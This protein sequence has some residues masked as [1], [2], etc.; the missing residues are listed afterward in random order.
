M[1]VSVSVGICAYNEAAR[2]GG[3]LGSLRSVD[4]SPSFIVDEIL[5]VASG[6][7]DGTEEEV[8]RAA[9]H[10]ARIR[11]VVEPTRRGK[12]SALNRILASYRGDILVLV[13]ADARPAPGALGAL[14]RAFEEPADTVVACGAAVPDGGDGLSHLVEEVQWDLHNRILAIQSARNQENH[15]CDELMA[16]R[17]GF[18][19]S[20]PPDLINDGAY[21]GVFAALSGRTVRFCTDARVHVHTP[22]S[23]RG[24]VEQRRRIL[25]G[26]RQIRRMLRR[27]P[28]TLER[29]ST[30]DP[31]LAA[32]IL[33]TEIR[34]RPLALAILLLLAL[35]LELASA[36]LAASDEVRRPDYTPVWPKVDYL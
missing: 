26:H 35:P 18:V 23:V 2:V 1:A 10:D 34:A 6:C 9:A 28:S 11:L 14:L 16:M 8:Q 21:L 27:S 32:Q 24:L 30:R 12:A 31:A 29:L 5:V 22:R 15:C 33:V 4:V 17:R 36:A 3:L 20:L 7:T 19:D 25:R 13:N